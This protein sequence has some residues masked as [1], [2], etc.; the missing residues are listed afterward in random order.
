MVTACQVVAAAGAE[1]LEAAVEG[2]DLPW[3]RVEQL[4][5]GKE[6]EVQGCRKG[7]EQRELAEQPP[8]RAVVAVGNKRHTP[9][10]AAERERDRQRGRRCR[11]A[12]FRRRRMG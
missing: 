6:T 12:A 8:A 11:L 9:V 5:E 4:V 1:I 10:A 3:G 7:S 2:T